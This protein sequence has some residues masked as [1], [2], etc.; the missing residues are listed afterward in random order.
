MSGSLEEKEILRS[1][2]S[3]NDDEIEEEL[4]RY[5]REKGHETHQGSIKEPSLMLCWFIVGIVTLYVI[6]L[7]I[8]GSPS[9]QL[10]DEL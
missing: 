7:G 6:F 9:S 3:L 1:F 2:E 10:K 4:E 5:Y 8:Q